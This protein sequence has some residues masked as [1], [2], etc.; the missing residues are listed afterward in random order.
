MPRS[1]VA[2]VVVPACVRR[3][4][5]IYIF[6]LL[7]AIT[8]GL[9]AP[10]TARA[11]TS[12]G[13]NNIILETIG[14]SIAVGTVLGASTLS[15]YEQ[16]GDHLLN[17]AYG[18]GIGLVAGMGFLAYKA[19]QGSSD[20]TENAMNSKAFKPDSSSRLSFEERLSPGLSGGTSPSEVRRFRISSVPALWTPVVSLTW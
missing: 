3:I 12:T 19:L 9:S 4:S 7:A 13:S 14:V 2:L 10:R 20:H 5:R 8:F 17:L 18:A 11:S 15:F 6:L 1:A 16:P